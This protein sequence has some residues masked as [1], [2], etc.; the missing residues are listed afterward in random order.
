MHLSENRAQR[1]AVI[2]GELHQTPGRMNV[3]E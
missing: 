3:Q 1:L 2:Q